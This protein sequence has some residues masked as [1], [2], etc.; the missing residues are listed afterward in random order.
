MTYA[1]R[2]AYVWDTW[3]LAHQGIVHA[4]HL[5]MRRPGAPAG[6]YDSIGHA[7]SRDLISW[8]G[9]PNAFSPDPA[10]PRDDRQPWTG[11]AVWHQG[12]GHLFYTMRG[13]AAEGRQQA[14][15]LATTSDPDRW[16]HHPGNPVILPDPRWY[17]TVDA[18][19]PGFLDCRDLAVAWD[20]ASGMW[21]GVFAARVP[22][23]ELPETSV[24]GAA[25]SRDLVHWEVL[26]PAFAPRKYA[27]I[28]APDLFHLD[29]KWYV[30]VLTGNWYG[31]RGIFA[32]PDL[33]DGTIWAVADRPEGPYR[34]L[35][36]PVFIAGRTTAPLICKT[37]ESAGRRHVLHS[38]RERVGGSD[39]GELAIVGTLGTPKLVEVRGGR[40]VATWC[41]RVET[42]VA[43]E[44]VG[45]GAPPRRG[46]TAWGQTWPVSSARWSWGPQ[47]AG[48][49]R[50]G[51][52]VAL[53]D[54]I[55]AGSC[56]IEATVTIESGHAAGIAFRV[57]GAKTASLVYLDAAD[58]VVSFSE[59][60]A[61]DH[62][63]RRRTPVA[64]AVPIRLRVVSRR[65]HVEVYVDDELRLAFTRYRALSGGVGLFVDRARARFDA[66][67]VRTLR[68]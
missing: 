41:P 6:D 10:D 59:G 27:C 31:N 23:D 32:D 51:W 62:H 3:F 35:A 26:P 68:D 7:V 12:R 42:L 66:I 28:E 18:P 53:F 19:V 4:Y 46:A 57:D 67:R 39:A 17:A 14:I 20:P 33:S 52:G 49:S 16:I 25:R 36:D 30:T 34:E 43:G 63:E 61:F 24:L 9:R 54:G 40:L 55:T 38:V 56:I 50:S 37:V 22:A 58:Q 45:P 8:E 15:G 65:E 11:S 2:D 1:P 44:P 13:S 29:G 5:Q 60:I 21:Y 47:I 48:E 64:R